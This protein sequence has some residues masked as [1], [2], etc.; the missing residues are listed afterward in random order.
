MSETAGRP[1][2]I[3][4]SSAFRRGRSVLD[5]LRQMSLGRLLDQTHLAFD[6]RAMAYLRVA[7]YP[8]VTAAHGHLF[9]TMRFEGAR[10][11][12]MAR[13]ANVSKQAMS[14]LVASFVELGFLE[15]RDDPEDGRSRIVGITAAGRRLLAT[16]VE[17]LKR[18]EADYVALLGA[19][20]LESLRAL[21][22]RMRDA[23]RALPAVPTASTRRRRRA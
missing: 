16:A 3:A 2:R 20:D 22:A 4:A 23:G 18:T 10:V 8:M 11:T 15:W 9:R 7:G 5:H 21:L 17:A 6:R 1:S 13:Q 12:E 14:K 19:A